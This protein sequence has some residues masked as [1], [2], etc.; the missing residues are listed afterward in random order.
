[1]SL[2]V[3]AERM[4]RVRISSGYHSLSERSNGPSFTSKPRLGQYLVL[5]PRTPCLTRPIQ[6]IPTD[7]TKG[8]FVYCTL[9]GH[10]VVGPTSEETTVHDG[11]LPDPH[12]RKTLVEHAVKV[13]PRVC[14]HACLP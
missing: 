5:S 13:Y 12:T 9:Y 7:V 11:A 8:V 3:F 14:V 4:E 6:P 1:M 10:I 2:G